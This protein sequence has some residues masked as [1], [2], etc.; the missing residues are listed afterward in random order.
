MTHPKTG[1]SFFFSNKKI[2]CEVYV[3]CLL[4]YC[5]ITERSIVNL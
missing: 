2:R 1:L 5:S 4:S 3:H